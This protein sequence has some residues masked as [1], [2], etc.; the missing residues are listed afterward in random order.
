MRRQSSP[1]Q[2]HIEASLSGEGLKIEG[3]PK[4]WVVIPDAGEAFDIASEGSN[5]DP[6]QADLFAEPVKLV[7]THR[8]FEHLGI[9][10]AAKKMAG[11]SGS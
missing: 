3:S 7:S 1:E 10:L 2:R 8:P 6:N 5:F 9:Q 4:S 11:P